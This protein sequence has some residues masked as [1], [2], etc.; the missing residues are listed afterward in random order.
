MS[1]ASPR[2]IEQ[3]AAIM[4]ERGLTRVQIDGVV[5]ERPRELVLAEAATKLAPEKPE[6][7]P[8]DAEL[9]KFAGLTPDAQDAA[10]ARAMA[11]AR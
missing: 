9:A 11:G 3:L 8:E 10:M 7:A 6:D 5:L 1:G 2:D 4:V